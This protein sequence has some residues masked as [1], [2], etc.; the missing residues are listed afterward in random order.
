M[1]DLFLYF[2]V[3]SNTFRTDIYT[4]YQKKEVMLYFETILQV[5]FFFKLGRFE[6]NRIK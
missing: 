5:L 3:F 6:K 4:A 2:L 1:Q